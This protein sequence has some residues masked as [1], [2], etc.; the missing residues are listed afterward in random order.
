MRLLQRHNIS[1][2]YHITS[3][4]VSLTSTFPLYLTGQLDYISID[5][6]ENRLLF[7]ATEAD[8]DETL[9]IRK[10]LLKR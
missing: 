6:R 10:P 3:S 8:L 4:V 2:M 5:S 9:I 7:F 1:F